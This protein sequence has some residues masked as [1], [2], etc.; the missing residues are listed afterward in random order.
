MMAFTSSTV[1]VSISSSASAQSALIPFV[2][3]IWV[4]CLQLYS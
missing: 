4:S 2:I 1:I 3:M